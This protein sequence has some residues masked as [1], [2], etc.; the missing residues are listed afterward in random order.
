MAYLR[1]DPNEC[2]RYE[3]ALALLRGC[4]CNKPI[5]N[6]LKHSANG[7]DKDGFP[8]EHS[9]RVRETA[10]EA[11]AH[12]TEVYCEPGE[13]VEKKKQKEVV[14][15]P[16]AFTHGKGLMG[17]L[18]SAATIP[19]SAAT[20][21]VKNLPPVAVAQKEQPVAPTPP[22]PQWTV[23]Q[24]PTPEKKGLLNRIDWGNHTAKSL[25]KEALPPVLI[26]PTVAD[27]PVSPVNYGSVPAGFTPVPPIQNAP[28]STSASTT[29]S[30]SFVP[31]RPGE[32]TVTPTRGTVVFDGNGGR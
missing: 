19:P 24:T 5:M 18:A 12:C 9:C 2:V 22:A 29:N 27:A 30:A 23:V 32:E 13:A 1:F 7:S 17:I 21:Q 31:M 14:P 4:C 11:L 20:A 10:A 25:P 16:V 28:F 8:P 15:P 26:T 6:A 3:A